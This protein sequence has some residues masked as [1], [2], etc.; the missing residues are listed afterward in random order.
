MT[1]TD[2]KPK[3]H[4]A[5]AVNIIRRLQS[6]RFQ[7]VLAGG[8]VRDQLLGRESSDFDV[9]TNATPKEVATLFPQAQK[10]GA[11]F[12]VMLVRVGSSQ[13]EVA[14]FRTDGNYADGRRPETVTFATMQGDAA[15]RDFTING[16]YFDPLADDGSGQLI[17][18]VGGQ[19][20]LAA[21]LI[22]CIGSAEA[23]F[24]EDHLRLLRAGRFAARLGFGIETETL[25]AMVRCGPQLIRIAPE[26]IA[27]ELRRMLTPTSRVE[28]WNLLVGTG[29]VGVM[30][31]GP[32]RPEPISDALGRLSTSMDF[33]VALALVGLSTLA[34]PTM[35]GTEVKV[36][37]GHLRQ[38]LRLSNEELDT[39]ERCWLTLAQWFGTNRPP[40]SV[41]HRD[42]VALGG[43]AGTGEVVD[44]TLARQRATQWLNAL[45]AWPALAP[46]SEE[47]CARLAG[48][49]H[50]A[51]APRPLLDGLR[52]MELGVPQGRWL[53]DLLRGAYDRQLDGDLLTSK[54]AEN[55][56]V[57]QFSA[58]G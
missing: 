46:R 50:D 8:C 44:L 48:L 41:F 39:A 7:A 11:A 58:K 42:V 55:W 30:F 51:L 24:A 32:V 20:D 57:A 23:R 36:A 31:R 14:T 13:V 40:P 17:D 47:L 15:R 25:A 52:L 38:W 2:S 12:G 27:D 26:R 56:A 3:S 43:T 45:T 1:P 22:R 29:L 35:D 53:G 34:S 37:R 10:V 21:R 54:E 4:R 28:A 49:S 6:A 18:L 16:M 9:A 19:A 33:G 5:D